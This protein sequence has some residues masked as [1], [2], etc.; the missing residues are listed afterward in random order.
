MAVVSI[1]CAGMILQV[2][3]GTDKNRFGDLRSFILAMQHIDTNGGLPPAVLDDAPADEEN[4]MLWPTAHVA[5]YFIDQGMVT[6]ASECVKH[7]ISGHVLLSMD[8]NDIFSELELPEG[9]AEYRKFEAAIKALQH[10]RPRVDSTFMLQQ[11]DDAEPNSKRRRLTKVP[12]TT[13]PSAPRFVH[14]LGWF[15]AP[16]WSIIRAT[17]T[18]NYVSSVQRIISRLSLCCSLEHRNH[19]AR[20]PVCVCTFV[21]V[22][23]G[24]CDSKPPER[25]YGAVPHR[26]QC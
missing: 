7:A 3:A 19:A 13:T 16:G 12:R 21:L 23:T 6:A 10:A 26:S 9:N 11:G 5:A 24:G 17:T 15:L 2:V 1:Y 4:V 22:H 8:L 25:C 18:P 20:V 14:T